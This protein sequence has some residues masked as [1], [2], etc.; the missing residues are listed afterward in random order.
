M[1]L[2]PEHGFRLQA[3]DVAARITPHSRVLFLNTPHN[4][5][6]AVLRAEDVA[7]LGRL[8]KAHDLWILSDEVYEELIFGTGHFASPLDLAD[9]AERT[10]AVSSISKS[11]AAFR[12]PDGYPGS[13]PR[14]SPPLPGPAGRPP[15]RP[16]AFRTVRPT[17]RRSSPSG[18]A[19]GP[20]GCTWSA[21]A[22][23]ELDVVRVGAD[24]QRFYFLHR[25]PLR[26]LA[27]YA[28]CAGLFAFRITSALSGP[29]LKIR[30]TTDRCDWNP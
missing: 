15:A 7:A 22:A 27:G 10:I 3:E 20:S 24:G 1:P 17:R 4:P 12:P 26:F 21:S 28:R 9:L 29:Q 25:V 30:S 19:G 6:G 11:H 8:A 23:A 14:K 16:C 18:R 5:T 13:R 2:H